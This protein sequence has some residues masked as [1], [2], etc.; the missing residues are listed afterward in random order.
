M[1]SIIGISK[2]RIRYT[3]IHNL[4][5]GGVITPEEMEIVQPLLEQMDDQELIQVVLDSHFLAENMRKFRESQ[6]LPE[7]LN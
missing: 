3:T 5:V 6:H 4:I 2:E 1:D 7:R